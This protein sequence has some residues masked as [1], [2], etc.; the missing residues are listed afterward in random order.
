MFGGALNKLNS[1]ALMEKNT[2]G[3]M[4]CFLA[5]LLM[6]SSCQN[7]ATTD[8]YIVTLRQ[9]PT[10][11]YQHKLTTDY[12]NFRHGTFRRTALHNPR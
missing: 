12:N 6:H 3:A 9:A 4:L 1:K 2:Y 7:D 11:H 10:S 5:M 8:V